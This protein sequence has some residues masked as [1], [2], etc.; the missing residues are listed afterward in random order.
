[1]R[2]SPFTR[3][4][5]PVEPTLQWRHVFT[6]LLGLC[7]LHFLGAQ[8]AARVSQAC[9]FAVCV[10]LV[11]WGSSSFCG[12]ERGVLERVVRLILVYQCM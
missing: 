1:M 2:M 8:N 5:G 10:A 3:K 6:S 9:F 4:A 11:V 7:S 12:R